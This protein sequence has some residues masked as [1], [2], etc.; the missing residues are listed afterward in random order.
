MKTRSSAANLI[1]L[2][3]LLAAALMI[4]AIAPRAIAE[5][6]VIKV[7]FARPSKE[8]IPVNVLA[9]QSCLVIFDQPIG[10]LAVSNQET[11][12]AVLVAPDQMTI[13][14]KASSRA[15]LTVW[16]KDD[17]QF[18]FLDVDVRANLAQIDSQV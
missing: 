3:G 1:P 2:I 12:E 18:I 5:D 15:R 4:F 13:N 17:S 14:G 16:S 8:P 11:A 7:S 10:R 6:T 9:G